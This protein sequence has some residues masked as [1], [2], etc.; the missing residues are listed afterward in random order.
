MLYAIQFE[1]QS[2][3]APIGIEIFQ[4]VVE[5]NSYTDAVALG[6]KAVSDYIAGLH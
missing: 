6:E 2:Q 4:R 3:N 5:A 1:I